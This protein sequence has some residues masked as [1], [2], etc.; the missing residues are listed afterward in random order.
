MYQHVICMRVFM[1][2]LIYRLWVLMGIVG[3]IHHNVYVLFRGMAHSHRLSV[4]SF[5]IFAFAPKVFFSDASLEP[6]V[7]ETYMVCTFSM[8]CNLR[9]DMQYNAILEN[10]ATDMAIKYTILA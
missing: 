10:N 6:D 3:I 2:M 1:Y 9:R 7:D 5:F 4:F 8:Q